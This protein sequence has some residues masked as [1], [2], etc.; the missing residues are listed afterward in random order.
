MPTLKLDVD[1]ETYNRLVEQAVAERRPVAW[2]AEVALRRA[3]G[4]SFP[5][6]ESALPDAEAPAVAPGCSEEVGEAVDAGAD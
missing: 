1:C 4:L 3:L 6:L 2:Q 5:H